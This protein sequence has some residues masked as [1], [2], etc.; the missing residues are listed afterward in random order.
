M[1]W[2]VAEIRKRKGASFD[3]KMKMELV[4]AYSKRAKIKNHGLFAWVSDNPV[5]TS[6]YHWWQ[7]FLI[8]NSCSDFL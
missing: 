5:C 4:D 3:Q 2:F 8:F 7:G 1:R 6:N